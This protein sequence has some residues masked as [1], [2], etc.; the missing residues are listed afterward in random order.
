MPYHIALIAA[1]RPI[2]SLTLPLSVLPA[3]LHC[4][5]NA[6][7]VLLSVLLVQV[8]SLNVGRRRRVGVIQ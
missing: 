7:S 8:R 1:P 4:L 5:A 2:P 3:L 6:L